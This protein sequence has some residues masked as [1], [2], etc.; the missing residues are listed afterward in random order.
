MPSM[1][2][3]W[4]RTPVL[5]PVLQKGSTPA[6]RVLEDPRRPEALPRRDVR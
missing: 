1:V 3:V 4:G 2:A 5:R 6:K